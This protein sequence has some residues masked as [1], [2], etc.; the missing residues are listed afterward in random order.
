MK[1]I[2]LSITLILLNLA[3]G[4]AVELYTNL[5]TAMNA[6]VY[7]GPFT[8]GDTLTNSYT[9]K[10]DLK[11][12]LADSTDIN[13]LSC[14]NG[15]VFYF[16]H[17]YTQYQLNA[18]ITHNDVWLNTYCKVRSFDS[19]SLINTDRSDSTDYFLGIVA[20][21]VTEDTNSLISKRSNLSS[22]RMYTRWD[23]ENGRAYTT[24]TLM[25]TLKSNET[26]FT[27]SDNDS[28]TF[29]MKIVT[30]RAVDS[31]DRAWSVNSLKVTI[32]QQSKVVE[33]GSMNKYSVIMP[34][35]NKSKINKRTYFLNGKIL[36]HSIPG[37]IIMI[38]PSTNK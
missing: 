27:L 18:S 5:D 38:S 33:K 30:L 6:T 12:Y 1:K 32:S 19:L 25:I 28:L 36:E 26:S 15:F 3:P 31:K 9:K 14:I 11:F 35:L 2:K 13:Y 4:F 8:A 21:D 22:C 16:V 34:F 7:M 17:N 29:S 24:V 20:S 37:H 10:V 23:A